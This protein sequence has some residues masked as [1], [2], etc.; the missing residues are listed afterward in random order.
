MQNAHIYLTNENMNALLP[1][2]IFKNC[3]AFEQAP[4]SHEYLQM[5]YVL[6]GRCTHVLNGHS[7]EYSRF[8][9]FIIPPYAAHR[10]IST[11]A[12]TEL[13][14]CEFSERFINESLMSE[15]RS[16][17]FDFAY[18]EPFFLCENLIHTP[19]CI[20]ADA[21]PQIEHLLLAL[22]SEFQN[23][24]KYSYLFIKADL[25]K[26]LAVIASEYEA[27]RTPAQSALFSRSYDAIDRARAYVEAHFAEKL[28]LEDVCRIAMM[29]HSTFSYIFKQLTGQTFSEYAMN[30]RLTRARKLLEESA[31][32]MLEICAQCGFS[33]SNYFSRA[34]KRCFGVSPS[35]YR[36]AF[37]ISENNAPQKENN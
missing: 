14:C 3:G 25:L 19:Y 36:S 30:L 13:L 22:L 35:A 2:K 15:E 33:D 12:R 17:L 10:I 8:G 11:D 37:R 31:L 16:G 18:L 29:S 9:L 7:Y 21:A 5:W 4:H 24:R 28:Y 20:S 6:S 26:L 23:P 34:F 32:P 1:F 27:R